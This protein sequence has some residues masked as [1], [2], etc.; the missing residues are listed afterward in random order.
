M[1]P[2]AVA[3]ALSQFAWVFKQPG[4]YLDAS[5]V[6]EPGLEIEDARDRLEEVMRCLPE[7][8]RVDLGRLLE[9]LDRELERRT[10]PDPVLMRELASDH[11]WWWRIRER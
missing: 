10:L 5:E 4:R 7:G 6:W 3:E 8:A 1:W 11:W 9:R 2:N